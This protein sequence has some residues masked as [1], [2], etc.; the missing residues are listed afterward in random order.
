[1]SAGPNRSATIGRSFGHSIRR[2][3]S[4]RYRASLDFPRSRPS[5]P[6]S[7]VSLASNVSEVSSVS[8]LFSED[9]TSQVGARPPPPSSPSTFMDL[10]AR[11]ASQ[12]G[13]HRTSSG[14]TIGDKDNQD[15]TLKRTSSGSGISMKRTSSGSKVSFN[16]K[17]RSPLPDDRR[18]HLAVETRHTPEITSPI[19]PTSSSSGGSQDSDPEMTLTMYESPV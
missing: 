4:R 5:R 7:L 2:T 6:G 18:S 19:P 15:D 12:V 16:F 10:G 9:T 11:S 3:M 14:S 13:L 1:M 17:R 8:S